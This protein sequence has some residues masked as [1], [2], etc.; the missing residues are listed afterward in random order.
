MKKRFQ[1]VNHLQK[2]IKNIFLSAN[3]PT[4][5]FLEWYKKEYPPNTATPHQLSKYYPGGKK[6]AAGQDNFL[7]QITEI[8]DGEIVSAHIDTELE[9]DLNVVWPKIKYDRSILQLAVGDTP[10]NKKI[11]LK[12]VSIKHLYIDQRSNVGIDIINCAIAHL[13][14]QPPLK[15]SFPT[16]PLILNSP[17]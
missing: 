2:C 14:I 4:D 8:G 5:D 3:R 17:I 11:T 16:C 12:G 9:K 15:S 13:N 6:D 7:K 1:F 10:Q